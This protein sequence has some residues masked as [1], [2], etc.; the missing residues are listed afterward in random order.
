[1]KHF[2]LSAALALAADAS[3]AQYFALL[4]SPELVM[5]GVKKIALLDIQGK[6]GKEVT[7]MLTTQLLAK[8]RGS[9]YSRWTLLGTETMTGPIMQPN[10]SASIFELAERGQL[11]K[12]L[13]EQRLSNSGVVD[14]AQAAKLGKVLGI[15]AMLMGSCTYSTG[16]VTE[17]DRR[18]RWVSAKVTMK[19]VDVNTGRVLGIKTEEESRESSGKI[20]EALVGEHDLA[21]SAYDAATVRLASYINPYYKVY[22]FPLE[23]VKLKAH[24]DKAKHAMKLVE[25][26]KD[27][28]A[29]YTIYKSISDDDPYCAEA[30]GN[31][32]QISLITG[33]FAQA[34][35]EFE[36]AA[37][38]DA[39]RYRNQV[40]FAKARIA[41]LEVLASLNVHPGS[42]PI[43]ATDD[44]ALAKMVHT[45][46]GK[47]DRYSVY[48]E[49]KAAGEPVA[50][51]PGDTKFEILE[52]SGEWILIKL[53]GGK[54]GYI[55]KNDVRL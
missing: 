10:G 37:E 13:A 47:G 34:L 24:A 18:K 31:M 8:R 1:M 42:V 50:K 2:I 52:T 35:G 14:D 7:D 19:V 45:R 46:G 32:G 43:A 39:E 40:E 33:N 3:Q 6:D 51:V 36:R 20:G 26:N 30:L 9:L 4:T 25:D 29:A 49:A 21:I 55:S 54:Q 28:A 22:N 12:V 11:E 53:L 5:P 27:L 16:L 48:S 15:D 38:I 23:K 41:E 44:K 17:G